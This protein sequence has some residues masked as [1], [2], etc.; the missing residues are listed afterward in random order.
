M[1]FGARL[2]VYG[3]QALGS[4]TPGSFQLAQSS[5][6]QLVTATCHPDTRVTMKCEREMCSRP[7][8]V[9]GDS[10]LLK[11]FRGMPG[12][13]LQDVI[14]DEETSCI[15]APFDV[16]SICCGENQWKQSDGR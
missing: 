6:V 14:R 12:H 8:M 7:S 1:G 5:T 11:P 2:S 13:F 15:E 4:M 16:G 3:V 9:A 10:V